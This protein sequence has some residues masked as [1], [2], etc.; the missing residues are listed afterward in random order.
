MPIYRR[1]I[2]DALNPLASL[3]E[4]FYALKSNG[5]VWIVGEFNPRKLNEQF[6]SI[7]EL[8]ASTWSFKKVLDT[9]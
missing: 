9:K 4:C 5:E 3:S 6:S 2:V 1:G 8:E 7:E